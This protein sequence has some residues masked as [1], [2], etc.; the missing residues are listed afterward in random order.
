MNAMKADVIIVGGG[1]VGSILAIGLSQQQVKVTILEKT[2]PL[3]PEMTGDGRTT[4]VSYGSQQIFNNLGLWSGIAAYA[5]PIEEIRVFEEGSAWTVD[6]HHRDIGTH[7]MGYI[8]ENSL[9]RHHLQQNLQN[10]PLITWIASADVL[11]TKRLAGKVAV[12]LKDGQTLEAL[13]LVGAEGRH[14]PTRQQSSITTRSWDYS[15]TALVVHL[16]HTKPHNNTAWEVFMPSGPLAIL[17][18]LPCPKTGHHRSGLVWAKP[19]SHDWQNLS[20]EDLAAQIQHYFPFY[21]DL[22]VC[23]QKWTYPLSA[24]TTSS[25]VDH[26]LAL[27]GDAAHVVH[28]IAGQ[29]VNLGWRD[30]DVLAAHLGKA[31]QLGLDIGSATVLDVYNKKRRVDQRSVLWTTDGINRLF[32]FDNSI[33]FFLR[34]SGFALVNNLPPLKRLLMRKAMGV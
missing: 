13:L 7:P 30:A 15:Q 28:P 16:Y 33:L 20:D 24:L 5:Q 17:P 14:S 12:N 4:A 26:R 8:V 25:Y 32:S 10:N 23:S 34:N 29:G 22:T 2:P 18:M 27:V 9:L 11:S 21:G 19:L 31:H 6:Y 1:L 3:S